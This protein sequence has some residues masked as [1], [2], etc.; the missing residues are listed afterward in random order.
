MNDTEQ[1]A[2]QQDQQ[3]QQPANSR[4]EYYT[5]Q[6]QENQK[7]AELATEIDQ[8]VRTNPRY[9]EFFAPY[10]PKVRED[11]VRYYVRDKL[12]WLRFGDFYERQLTGQLTQFEREAYTRLW[13]IQ[14]KKLFD[15]QCQWRAEQ[16][17]VPGVQ[18]SCD[19]EDLSFGIENCA[20]LPPISEDELALYLRFV[21]QCNYEEDLLDRWGSRFSWQ[22]YEDVKLAY[23]DDDENSHW[24]VEEVPQWY[25]YHN[26]HTGNERL[27][28]LPD[29]RGEKEKRYLDAWRANNRAAE[30]A[31]KQAAPPA[32][33]PTDTRPDYLDYNEI[34]AMR[35]EFARRFESAQVNRQRQSYQATKLPTR[36][37]NSKTRN[38]NAS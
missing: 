7:Y 24:P 9:D 35:D 23:A 36:R 20:V 32:A 2:G 29:V 11:F 38:W 12:M 4:T 33:P 1:P 3:P 26:Q 31:R 19:F 14:Q 6:A 5:K 34:L 17:Q 18:L 37:P 21:E 22:R 10:Q 28:Q 16:V 13:D 30:E 27:L 8:D 15:L 25:L